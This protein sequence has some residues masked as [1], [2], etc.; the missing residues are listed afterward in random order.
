MRSW[1]TSRTGRW[2]T[3]PQRHQTVRQ[4]QEPLSPLRR[5]RKVV[6][7]FLPVHHH[8]QLREVLHLLT[9]T[10]DKTLGAMCALSPSN[11][12]PHQL[13]WRRCDRV[14][15]ATKRRHGCCNSR[16]FPFMSPSL[17]H[18]LLATLVRI[19]ARSFVN[20]LN[21][22]EVPNLMGAVYWLATPKWSC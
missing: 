15:S 7:S 11:S 14:R 4:E 5:E 13:Q 6:F 22:G 18:H 19:S 1:S 9:E 20:L 3:R 12:I 8:S 17:E 21:Q 2:H 16:S 10:I